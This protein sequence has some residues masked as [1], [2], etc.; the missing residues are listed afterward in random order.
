MGYATFGESIRGTPIRS[1]PDVQA[2]HDLDDVRLSEEAEPWHPDQEVARIRLR[3]KPPPA[4][5]IAASTAS[6]AHQFG[7]VGGSVLVFGNWPLSQGTV[8]VDCVLASEVAAVIVAVPQPVVPA[9]NA[10]KTFPLQSVVPC[11]GLTDAPVTPLTVKFT[12][13]RHSGAPAAFLKLKVKLQL[14]SVLEHPAVTA[15]VPP[16]A[17]TAPKATK[18]AKAATTAMSPVATRF[19]KERLVVARVKFLPP[20]SVQAAGYHA[21][22]RPG[23]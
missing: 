3:A 7:V 19:L 4:T 15:P 11:V 6:P 17:D 14:V 21:C 9:E 8:T 16:P 20:R 10:A 13:T 1:R 12:A 5:I 18:P 2:R 22:A 23:Q